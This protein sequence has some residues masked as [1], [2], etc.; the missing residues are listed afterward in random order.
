[1][2]GYSYEASK[3]FLNFATI[4][5]SDHPRQEFQRLYVLPPKSRCCGSNKAEES[6]VGVQVYGCYWYSLSPRTST[7]ETGSHTRLPPWCLW[8]R[9]SCIPNSS[10]SRGCWSPKLWPRPALCSAPE[11]QERSKTCSTTPARWQSSW[12]RR[13]THLFWR[14]SAPQC[15]SRSGQLPTPGHPIIQKT[16]C[17]SIG[18]IWWSFFILFFNLYMLSLVFDLLD[19]QRATMKWTV[20]FWFRANP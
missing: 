19:K 10:G 6:K 3:T 15:R 4:P 13:A 11:R 18:M 12:K 16:G 9:S 20:C 17:T 2:E 8:L 1:M 7:P 5:I 14:S